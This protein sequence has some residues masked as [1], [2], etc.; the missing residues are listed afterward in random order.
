VIEIS[1]QKL[2]LFATLLLIIN[3]SL[4]LVSKQLDIL[5]I[6]IGLPTI[7]LM[8]GLFSVFNMGARRIS[9]RVLIIAVALSVLW[10]MIIGLIANYLPMILGYKDPLNTAAVP[11]LFTALNT[12]L[13]LIYFYVR[14]NN[15]N[16][17]IPTI[18]C[19]IVDIALIAMSLSVLFLS[20]FGTF[21]LNNNGSD[22]LNML[23]LLIGLAIIICIFIFHKK[24][25]HTSLV[26]V[27]YCIGLSLLLMTSLRGWNISSA[28]SNREYM[29]YE[30]TAKLGKWSM[31]NYRNGYNACLSITILPVI[32]AK[33]LHLPN[34][35]LF[36]KFLSQA[37]FAICPV[38]MFYF[39]YNYT[40]KLY[41]VAG[42]LL[43]ITYPIFISSSPLDSRQE[44]AFMF[45]SVLILIWYATKEEWIKDY[46]KILF[47]AMSFGII[48]SHYSTT[49]TYVI[50]LILTIVFRFTTSFITH[51]KDKSKVS[52]TMTCIVI[53][54]AFIWYAQ[55]TQASSQLTDTV[56]DS[57]KNIPHLLSQ[58]NSS[59]GIGYAILGNSAGENQFFEYAN[60]LDKNRTSSMLSSPVI[61]KN[62][63]IPASNFDTD[64]SN[65]THIDLG[66]IAALLH[67]ADS[68]FYQ[69][70]I[71]LGIILILS[72]L[73][74]NK[75]KDI[76]TEFTFFSIAG[77]LVLL[78]EII[79]PNIALSYGLARALQQ[80]LIF[81]MLPVV[82]ALSW[83][84]SLISNHKIRIVVLCFLVAEFYITFTGFLPQLTGGQSPQYNLNNSGSQYSLYYYHQS[85]ALAFMWL[86]MNVS[87]L[88]SVRA[89]YYGTA[90]ADDYKYPFSKVGI[91]PDQINSHD[92][93]VL[94]YSQVRN[95]IVYVN[96][97]NNF[98]PVYINPSQYS[99]KSRLYSNNGD[100][101]FR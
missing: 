13:I 47:M 9:P 66:K 6:I 83:L 11:I 35:L 57:F 69:L 95:H 54:C 97:K 50:L 71:L 93:V 58:D 23:S 41:S 78:A 7:L 98:Y 51:K 67:P 65:F 72:K 14:K 56:V 76:A 1:K 39:L 16:I 36:Y 64:F 8:P 2:C 20:I 45:F 10:L 101:I 94:G 4:F 84:L 38:S 61:L 42:S 89:A 43:F 34:G 32:F 52:Y 28:D 79:L 26:V 68:R 60:T 59:A 96:V 18:K 17:I 80:T 87:K 30:L 44:I 92:Y 22:A 12:F 91:L 27:I 85:D 49:Y 62:D 19:N 53:L 90:Y 21:H 100:Q 46:W 24:I 31:A 29:V 82:I 70:S 37:L 3:V 5:Q 99:D 15:K 77:I 55:A 25:S 40:N 73:F 74:R 75:L 63:K 33:L 86:K 48:I 81:M 88:S